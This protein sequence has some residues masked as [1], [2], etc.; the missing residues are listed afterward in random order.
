MERRETSSA[1]YLGFKAIVRLA[2]AWPRPAQQR[3]AEF[4][5]RAYYLLDAQARRDLCRNL[6]RALPPGTPPAEVRR[7][8]LRAF[9]S[10]GYYL[11]EFLSGNVLSREFIDRHVMVSGREHLDAAL[12]AGRGA[13]FCTGH[14]SN[15][16][17]AAAVVARMGYP[18]LAIAQRHAH[19]DADRLFVE[20]RRACGIE[21]AY[22]ATGARAALRE[23]AA[24]RTVGILGD[25]PTGEGNVPVE[26]FGA[27]TALPPGP[28]RLALASGAALLP[29]FVTRM[30][31]EFILEIGAPLPRPGYTDRDAQV[32]ALA[33]SWA[34][35]FEE[36]IKQ[37]P[38]QWEAFYPV[39][40][41]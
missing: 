16:E 15:W 29:G 41:A 24:N 33:Q 1:Q 19:P 6:E 5:A 17:L 30:S 9:E 8:A 32:A 23:L 10:F 40:P 4:V 36:K 38:G 27:R 13:L 34:H 14:F 12:R 31:D 11:A 25:R 2:R 7:T 26:F 37:A 39:W 21:I 20:T 28:W 22:S 3:I 35:A 18:I